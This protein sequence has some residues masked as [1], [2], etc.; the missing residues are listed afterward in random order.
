MTIMVLVLRQILVVR[1]WRS[2]PSYKENFEL[3]S[4]ASQ[5]FSPGMNLGLERQ[6]R[7]TKRKF[8]RFRETCY[9]HGK[10]LNI[11]DNFLRDYLSNGIR[12][13][14]LQV[15]LYRPILSQLLALNTSQDASDDLHSSFKHDGA[16]ACVRSSI[17]LISLV[18]ETFRTETAEAWWWN[19]LC[20]YSVEIYWH[21]LIKVVDACTASL[22]LMTCRLCPSLWAT[23]DQASVIDASNK[24]HSVLEVISTFSLSIRKSF[25]LL[26][27]M[28]Q[29]ITGRQQGQQ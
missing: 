6:S 24:C 18:H 16:R 5:I 8:S 19:S 21:S 1:V 29:T 12:F 13:T 22:V 7:Y 2:L 25:N 27:K 17:Q 26:T 11:T 4:L 20:R 14:Y 9:S 23:L 10:I 15:M 3:S 28:H